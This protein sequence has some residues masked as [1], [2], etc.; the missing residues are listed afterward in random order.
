MSELFKEIAPQ[1]SN[2]LLQRTIRFRY[3]KHHKFQVVG[4]VSTESY[5]AHNPMNIADAPGKTGRISKYSPT[6]D[7]LTNKFIN[8]IIGTPA[9]PIIMI[10]LEVKAFRVAPDRNR[11]SSSPH[12]NNIKNS[13]INSRPFVLREKTK[14]QNRI[15]RCQT[16]QPRFVTANQSPL[17]NNEL[18]NSLPRLRTSFPHQ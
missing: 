17:R 12:L 18:S 10:M 16:M 6:C 2:W 5:G 11:I 14:F 4:F 1:V 9:S 15:R 3:P 7:V 13:I 8:W